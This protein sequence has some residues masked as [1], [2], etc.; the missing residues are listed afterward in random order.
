MNK[1]FYDKN[2]ILK[3]E[4]YCVGINNIPNNYKKNEVVSFTGE[5]PFFGYPILENDT[6]RQATKY[7]LYLKNI[8]KLKKNEYIKDNQILEYST[9]ELKINKIIPLAS[10]EYIQDNKLIKTEPSDNFLLPTWN[11]EKRIW[12]EGTSEEGL[13]KEQDRILQEYKEKLFALGY[14]WNGHCQ[15]ARAKDIALLESVISSTKLAINKK[16]M[17][18]DTTVNWYFNR[19]DKAK[20]KLEDF[21]NLKL[22]GISFVQEVYDVEASFKE[23]IRINITFEEFLLKFNSNKS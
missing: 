14:N 18:Q 6:I 8:Y 10:G 2:K 15:K 13:I 17:T 3:G 22:A 21:Y 9:E 12:E 20:L 1:Y 16:I 19:N 7:E 11:I 5:Q 4:T 23:E